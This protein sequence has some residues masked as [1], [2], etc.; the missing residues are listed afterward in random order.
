MSTQLSLSGIAGTDGVV[1]VYEPNTRWTTWSLKEIYLGQQ[2]QNRYVPK[3][4]DYVVDIDTAQYYKV[5]SIDPTTM[6]PSLKKITLVNDGAFTDQDILLG[7]GPGTQS[8]TYRVYIDKS[9]MPYALAVDARLKVAGTMVSSAKIFKGS[10]IYGTSEVISAFYDQSGNLL[11]QAIPL[12]LVAMDGNISIRTVPVCHTTEN[13]ADGEIVTVVFFSDNGHV[14][15]KR[16]LLVENTAFIRST[17]VAT[18]YITGITLDSPFLSSGDPR[19]IQYPLNVPLSGLSLMGKVQYSDGS[20]L[21]MPVDGTKFSL[22][23]FEGYVA[24]IVG[25]KFPL[26]LKYSLSDNEIVYGA[27]VADGKFLTEQ[28]RATTLKADGAYTVKLFGYPVWIDATQGYRIEWFL[29]NL[30]RNVMYRVTPYVKFNQNTRVFDPTAYGVLQHLSVSIN[31]KDVNGTYRSY[32]HVQTIDIVLLAPGTD[33][34]GNWTVGFDPAQNPPYGNSMF[35]SYNMINAN[36]ST[37]QIDFGAATQEEWLQRI[38]L[39]TK[40]MMDESRELAAPTPDF[41]ALVLGDTQV[42]FPIS[43]WNSALQLT[44]SLTNSGTLFVKFFKRL[45]DTD[46]QLAVAGLPIYQQL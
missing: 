15:S 2:G 6:V 39:N 27:S 41:F 46:L 3:V 9:V 24:T 38:Y 23:G 7:V 18:K 10:E 4:N 11:G 35:A 31:L 12:E 33:R 26:V 14:V 16:Q 5:D 8:D 43:Q 28:Y 37:V 29:Y 19:L 21:T 17:D 40:P 25:Q 44:T 1:P 32:N 42:E 22:F 20:A 36:L 45:A 34:T 13:L 30:D